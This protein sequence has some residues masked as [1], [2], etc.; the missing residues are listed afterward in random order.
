MKKNMQIIAVLF[1]A[2]LSIGSVQA[3]N[4]HDKNQAHHNQYEH[5]VTRQNHPAHASSHLILMH[6]NVALESFLLLRNH[7]RPYRHQTLLSQ[8]FHQHRR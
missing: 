3:A 1:I 2:I 8:V 6:H 7:H 5:G 4:H